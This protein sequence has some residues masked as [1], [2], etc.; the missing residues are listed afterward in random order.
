[1]DKKGFISDLANKLIAGGKT[2]AGNDLAIELNLNNF[3]TDAGDQYKGKRG[4]Y[5]LIKSTHDWLYSKK[6][7]TEANNV[8]LAFPKPNGKYA[9]NK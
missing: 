9:Y 8:A 3:K 4:T 1:M 2:M 7:L 5:R 6:M